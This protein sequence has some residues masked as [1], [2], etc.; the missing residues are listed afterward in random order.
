MYKKL[1]AIILFLIIANLSTVKAQALVWASE[2]EAGELLG[3][4]ELKTGCK[5][6]SGDF[7]LIGGIE[8]SGIKFSSINVP[9]DGEY[10]LLI[11]YFNVSDQSSEI[12]VNDKSAGVA[13]FPK[14]TY[15][16]Q[17]PSSQIEFPLTL[18]KG[19]NTISI[20]VLSGAGSPYVDQVFLKSTTT[21]DYPPVNY[22]I[23]SSGN[24]SNLGTS[25]DKPWKSI[26]K[27]NNQILHPGDSILFKAS[28]IFDGSL[29]VIG[30][31]TA[32]SML[33]VGKYGTGVDPIING[34][35]GTGLSN[36]SAIT[37]NSGAYVELAHLELTNNRLASNPSISD[38]LAF[39]VYLVNSG[40]TSLKHIRFHDL[41]IHDV[42][43]FSTNPDFNSI[44]VAGIYITSAR[45]TVVGKESNIQDVIVENCYIAHTTRFGI[46]INHGGGDAGVGNDMLNRNMDI[47][48]RNNHFYQTGGSG[49]LM[50]QVYNGLIENNIFEYSGSNYDPRMAN[51]G[52]GAWYF[53]SR[54]VISQFNKSLHIRGDGDSYG[55]HIDFGNKDIILQYNYSEDSEGGFAEILGKNVNS[56]YRFNVSVNDGFRVKQ[57]NTFWISDYSAPVNTGSDSTFIY[58]NSIYVDANITPDINLVGKNMFIYNNI[59][60]AKGLG[61]IAATVNLSVEAGSRL[62]ISNNLYSG[63][64]NTLFSNSDTRPVFGDPKYSNPGGLNTDSYRI[65]TGSK[66]FKAGVSFPEP[67]FP[68]A[69][70]G[71]FKDIKEYPDKDL[72][73][74]KVNIATSIPNIGADNAGADVT[75]GVEDFKVIKVATFSIY[76]NP[77]K[78]VANVNIIASK[79]GNIK[80]YI[81]DLQGKILSVKEFPLTI[82]LNKLQISIDPKITNGIYVLSLEEKGNFVGKK[83]VVV[84]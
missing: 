11:N 14:G 40:N 37:I 82:G 18:K 83:I 47:I 61:K 66:A 34:S 68:A 50:A 49:I 26:D 53:N 65:G 63:N 35:S 30:S 36:L 75:T 33:Y 64:V 13:S 39:G 45:N 15:C 20:K 59:L 43:S 51:R 23:S 71:I 74:N 38:D 29:N 32:N 41:N 76:P 24:D 4:A 12:F 17:A 69:G 25:P 72:F 57:G 70:T 22:Y 79:K 44:K 8:G 73:G 58:N 16:Y 2:A 6:A 60:E 48:F 21:I 52:S 31:G 54:N 42:Y 77:V 19:I 67:K 3:S 80:T 56:T 5:N 9:Q 1:Y 46:Q 62:S 7:V 55:Q 84:R 28:E 27:M 78:S 81:S 10:K